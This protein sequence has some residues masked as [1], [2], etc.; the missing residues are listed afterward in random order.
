MRPAAAA[1]WGRWATAV[2]ACVPLVYAATRL[3]W[4]V[5][6]PLGLTEERLQLGQT[7]GAWAAGASLAAVAIAGAGLTLGLVQRWGEVV[8]RWVPGLGG[9]RVP[10]ALAVVPATLIALLVT[11]AGLTFWR[12]MLLGTGS[13]TLTGGNWAALLPELL[14]PVWGAALGA[15]ALAYHL[16]RRTPEEPNTGRAAAV[17]TGT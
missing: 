4:W 1:R 5:G 3:A 13:Y 12:R 9:K 15:A 16:R 7:E 10:P 2:A 11:N 6:L 14:W 17:T 8:P